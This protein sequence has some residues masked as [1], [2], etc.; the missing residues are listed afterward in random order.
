[1]V[2]PLEVVAAL[3]DFFDKGGRLALCGPSG[4]GK[5]TLAALIQGLSGAK[6]QREGA[7]EWLAEHRIGRYW[8]MRPQEVAEMQLWLLS[9]LE[10]SDAQIFDRFAVDSM[11]F[12]ERGRPALDLAKFEARARRM[13]MTVDLVIFMPYRSELLKADGVRRPDPLYQVRTG[14]KILEVL[15]AWELDDHTYLYEHHL[16]VFDN[17]MSA[18]SMVAPSHAIQLKFDG[19]VG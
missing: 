12:A 14:G 13:A 1:M 15:E 5:S 4:V 3:Q 19:E 2:T 10:N 8:L 18:I 11:V 9:E 16:S 17:L 7:R 6:L